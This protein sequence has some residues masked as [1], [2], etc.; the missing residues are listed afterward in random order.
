M[1]A[2]TISVSLLRVSATSAIR[3]NLSDYVT[4]GSIEMNTDRE[5]GK[6]SGS[7]TLSDGDSS[8]A[9]VTPSVAPDRPLHVLALRMG[10]Q[11]ELLIDGFTRDAMPQAVLDRS[12]NSPD[13]MQG[14][15]MEVTDS[16]ALAVYDACLPLDMVRNASYLLLARL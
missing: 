1:A 11:C 2:R 5:A 9:F 7:F 6:M 8:A 13:P 12:W 10:K 14:F 16:V 4:A 15:A 3:E